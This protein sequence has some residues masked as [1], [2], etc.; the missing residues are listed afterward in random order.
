MMIQFFKKKLFSKQKIPK[1]ALA[2]RIKESLPAWKLLTKDHQLL[3]LVEYYQI[4]L[5][6][7]PV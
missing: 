4:P 1:C 7:K 3:S 5:L 2:G 6:M